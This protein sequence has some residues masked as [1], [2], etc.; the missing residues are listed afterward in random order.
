MKKFTKLFSVALAAAMT[1][2]ASANAMTFNAPMKVS[3]DIDTWNGGGQGIFTGYSGSSTKTVKTE[4]SYIEGEQ[5]VNINTKGNGY[6]TLCSFCTDHTGTLST[7]YVGSYGKT[8]LDVIFKIDEIECFDGD[9][10]K[11]NL[12]LLGFDK[13]GKQKSVGL[14]TYWSDKD[15]IGLK[16]DANVVNA[17][18]AID[19]T[20]GEKK[21]FNLINGV[22]YYAYT[23]LNNENWYRCILD[24]NPIDDT[25]ELYLAKYDNGVEVV[26]SHMLLK[27]RDDWKTV[28]GSWFRY[29]GGRTD[30][31][32]KKENGQ[33]VEPEVII[34]NVHDGSLSL[35]KYE[36]TRETIVATNMQV[37]GESATEVSATIPVGNNSPANDAYPIYKFTGEWSNAIKFGATLNYSTNVDGTGREG[38]VQDYATTLWTR[39]DAKED[40][41]D[42]QRA[43]EVSPRI[44]LCQ[45]NENGKLLAINSNTLESFPTLQWGANKP[46]EG[47]KENDGFEFQNLTV[48]APKADGYSY[49]KAFVWDSL[50]GQVPYSAAVSTQATAAK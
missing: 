15:R 28:N 1:L 44:F 49:A 38:A 23:Q 8:R 25:C 22:Q 27:L 34:A 3:L 10:A 40:A 37:N 17:D 33:K 16:L 39:L 41:K 5:Y 20:T 24:V 6:N 9:N 13:D 35:G 47:L 19:L 45:Y 42:R 46:N 2:G 32:Y 7:K 4:N 43:K 50:A 30:I 48:T 29:P 18:D 14:T 26:Q 21:Q 31:A 36:L 12:Q 11:F